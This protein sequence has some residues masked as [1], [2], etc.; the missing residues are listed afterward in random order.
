MST[1]KEFVDEYAGRFVEATIRHGQLVT[2]RLVGCRKYEKA[3]ENFEVVVEDSEHD[4]IDHDNDFIYVPERIE[5]PGHGWLVHVSD[6]LFTDGV[7]RATWRAKE[8]PHVCP[9]C[10]DPAFVGFNMIECSRT[11]CE[12]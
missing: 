12:R 5:N 1:A 7:T 6:L 9:A 3:R 8:F 2:G 11:G 10:G 4:P